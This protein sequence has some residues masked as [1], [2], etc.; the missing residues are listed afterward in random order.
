MNDQRQRPVANLILQLHHR[1][2]SF[3]LV[4]HRHS[5]FARSD[6]YTDIC[7]AS[8]YIYYNSGIDSAG[9]DRR[10]DI[11]YDDTGQYSH[12]RYNFDS[13]NDRPDY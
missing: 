3:D 1:P 6:N 13:S 7:P 8:E 9:F 12:E 4:H 10:P 2:R 11:L 5:D